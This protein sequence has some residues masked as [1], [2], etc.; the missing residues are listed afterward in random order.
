MIRRP[1]ALLG[2]AWVL[3]HH[4]LLVTPRQGPRGCR[5]IGVVAYRPSGHGGS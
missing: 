5:S 1:W 2:V 3:A 4:G